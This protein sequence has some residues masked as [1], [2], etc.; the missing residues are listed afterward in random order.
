MWHVNQF[1]HQSLTTMQTSKIKQFPI[2]KKIFARYL[3]EYNDVNINFIPVY[4]LQ[5]NDQTIIGTKNNMVGTEKGYFDLIQLTG[6]NELS[7]KNLSNIY[8]RNKE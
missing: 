4:I 3:D 8:I 6:K 7:S 5:E 1:T 2:G